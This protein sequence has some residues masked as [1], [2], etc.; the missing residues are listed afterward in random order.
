MGY[1]SWCTPGTISSGHTSHILVFLTLVFLSQ[2]DYYIL[3]N[4]W[5]IIRK[6]R[7]KTMSSFLV[8]KRMNPWMEVAYVCIEIFAGCLCGLKQVNKEY[9]LC[10]VQSSPP[11]LP[12]MR[13]W[14]WRG[15]CQD[16]IRIGLFTTSDAYKRI[17]T[18]EIFRILLAQL[19]HNITYK[20]WSVV[21]YRWR[22]FL[23]L[24]FLS[25]L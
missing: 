5:N 12:N 23:V 2:N 7:L 25:N 22:V 21:F 11:L 17:S 19:L 15:F 10:Y 8:W 18:P 13:I 14:S 24:A 20:K 9:G 4:L 3:Y 1:T 6:L 16:P